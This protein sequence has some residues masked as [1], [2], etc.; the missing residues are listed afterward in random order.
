[1]VTNGCITQPTIV[2]WV[3]PFSFI[4]LLYKML[5]YIV[6]KLLRC[7]RKRLLLGPKDLDIRHMAESVQRDYLQSRDIRVSFSPTGRNKAKG[8]PLRKIM[9]LIIGH[10]G[11]KN[12]V[13]NESFFNT[14]PVR[15]FKVPFLVS[16][17]T[18]FLFPQIRDKKLLPLRERMA[19][20]HQ[21][22]ISSLLQSK[23]L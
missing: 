12:A 10:I 6:Q 13:G 8:H 20:G 17:E 2:D 19:A 16:Q 18:E 5:L 3:M 14:N 23:T 22:I 7:K 21:N 15:P 1:M 4:S 9:Q 11:G